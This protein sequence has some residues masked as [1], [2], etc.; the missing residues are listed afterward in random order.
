MKD[1][2]YSF[3]ND[4]LDQYEKLEKEEIFTV[5][6]ENGY[7]FMHKLYICFFTAV[8]F[9]QEYYSDKLSQQEN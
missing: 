9:F 1:K 6:D 5:K 7:N 2:F 3:Y 8:P 4:F